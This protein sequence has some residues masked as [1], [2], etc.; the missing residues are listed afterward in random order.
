MNFSTLGLVP[1]LWDYSRSCY[2]IAQGKAPELWDQSQTTLGPVPDLLIA[3][4]N[5]ANAPRIFLLL[6][7]PGQKTL[8]AAM[9]Q[10]YED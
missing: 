9:G 8:G 1:D 4:E 7:R 10:K 2:Q 5:N 6:S 3:E